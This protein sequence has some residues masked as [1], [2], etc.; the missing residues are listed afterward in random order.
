MAKT[1]QVVFQH[2]NDT[3]CTCRVKTLPCE[4]SDAQSNRVFDTFVTLSN[5]SCYT[6]TLQV[7][8]FTKETYWV[9]NNPHYYISLGSARTFI[10]EG[11]LN[12]NQM[13][14]RD[15]SKD[16]DTLPDCPD[17]DDVFTSI[18]LDG[19]GKPYKCSQVWNK[20]AWLNI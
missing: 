2:E 8:P 15:P 9:G 1:I 14:E 5:V 11:I 7:I 16:C 18:K 6:K 4:L 3:K 13:L 12:N 19:A 20:G 10:H 17:E